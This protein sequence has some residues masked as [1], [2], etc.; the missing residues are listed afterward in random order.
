MTEDLFSRLIPERSELNF[1]Q[2]LLITIFTYVYQTNQFPRTN[3]L[4]SVVNQAV[5]HN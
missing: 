2:V 5:R 3:Q 1:K 4:N